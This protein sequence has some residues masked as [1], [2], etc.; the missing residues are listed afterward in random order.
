MMQK[1]ATKKPVPPTPP[2]TPQHIFTQPPANAVRLLQQNTSLTTRCKV[3][4]ADVRDCVGLEAGQQRLEWDAPISRAI[5][6]L[7]MRTQQSNNMKRVKRL[8]NDEVS[9]SLAPEATF[10]V[11]SDAQMCTDKVNIH[12]I[13]SPEGVQSAMLKKV[14]QR[15]EEYDPFLA[16]RRCE[17]SPEAPETKTRSLDDDTSRQNQKRA[18]DMSGESIE[19]SHS[20]VSTASLAAPTNSSPCV[21]PNPPQRDNVQMD[22][23]VMVLMNKVTVVKGQ[24]IQNLRTSGPSAPDDLQ[25]EGACI[26]DFVRSEQAKFQQAVE[27]WRQSRTSN[28][29][30]QSDPCSQNHERSSDRRAATWELLGKLRDANEIQATHQAQGFLYFDRLHGKLVV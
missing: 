9:T 22:G 2:K 4:S 10:A 14:L 3:E 17:A 12:E 11:T 8:I 21:S 28:S 13:P 25:Q 15:I 29:K 18:A 24:Q 19:A 30:G 23:D 16:L 7:R 26:D 20:V 27:E 1:H 6:K 5:Q